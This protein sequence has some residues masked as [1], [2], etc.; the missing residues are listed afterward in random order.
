MD[1]SIGCAIFK[2]LVGGQLSAAPP[3]FPSFIRFLLLLVQLQNTV[4]I[5][6]VRQ[7]LF[8]FLTGFSVVGVGRFLLRQQL[9]VLGIQRL[10]GGQLLEAKP[11]KIVLCGLVDRDLTFMLCKKFLGVPGLAVAR[12][13][14][15]GLGVVDDLR[16]RCESCS[17]NCRTRH[18]R[19][20]GKHLRPYP[21]ILSCGTGQE[22]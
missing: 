17:R 22:V 15:A 20:A 2:S 1:K 14:V 10:D 5:G 6:L 9:G 11:I 7:Q 16:R 19:Y 4:D 12:V 18:G 13:N 21:A 3:L 8:H